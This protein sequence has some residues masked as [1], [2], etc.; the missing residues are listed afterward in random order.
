MPLS[1]DTGPAGPG[2]QPPGRRAAIFD[3]TPPEIEAR[4]IEGYRAMSPA[5]RL[6]RVVS[7]NRALE[8][9]ATARLGSRY[10][11]DLS[12]RELRLRLG[13]LRLSREEMVRAF[14]W[15]PVERGY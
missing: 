3:D 1:E 5:E 6:A 2:R 8:A 4:V 14:D 10:G 9:L 11:P 7:L 12:P 15:D 13:S